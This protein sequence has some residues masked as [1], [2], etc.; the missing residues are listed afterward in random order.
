MSGACR[1]RSPAAVGRR[2]AIDFELPA[3]LWALTGC[4]ASLSLS[5]LLG[6]AVRAKRLHVVHHLAG[7]GIHKHKTREDRQH[8]VGLRLQ[9]PR[10]DGGAADNDGGP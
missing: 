1:F 5:P 9:R 10:A 7:R 3:A 2:R 4:L 8:F 6:V